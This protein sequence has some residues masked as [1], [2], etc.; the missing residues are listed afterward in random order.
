M[1]YVILSYLIR[2]SLA[3]SYCNF[4]VTMNINKISRYRQQ[5]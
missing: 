2:P 5:L 1:I 3:N 4:K